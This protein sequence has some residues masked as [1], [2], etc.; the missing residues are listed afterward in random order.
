MMSVAPD[1]LSPYQD[2]FYNALMDAHSD[3]S[4]ANSQALNARLI[5]LMANHIG[6]LEVLKEL[7]NTA[8]RYEDV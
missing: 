8:R 2:E 5:L 6:E 1:R 3:L 7:I 4:D